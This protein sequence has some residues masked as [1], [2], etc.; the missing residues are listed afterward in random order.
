MYLL[1][2]KEYLISIFQNIFLFKKVL[3]C[4]LRKTTIRIILCINLSF[5]FWT[6][7]RNN[8]IEHMLCYIFGEK[9]IRTTPC[10]THQT[11]LDRD[12][13]IARGI[14]GIP[15]IAGT[16][17]SWQIALFT[18]VNGRLSSSRKIN[19]RAQKWVYRARSTWEDVIV[20]FLRERKIRCR[21]PATRRHWYFIPLSYTSSSLRHRISSRKWRRENL[22]I[23]HFLSCPFYRRACDGRFKIIK[24]HK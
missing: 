21:E 23:A 3:I 17:H 6:L 19:F 5:Q 4:L 9:Y 8:K 14:L 15:S 18:T 22:E 16:W 10:V 7:S 2:R 12:C 1:Y 11:D 20:S 24:H 13:F